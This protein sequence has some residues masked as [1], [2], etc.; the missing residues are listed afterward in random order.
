MLHHP[1][2][3]A[4]VANVGGRRWCGC[5]NGGRQQPWVADGGAVGQEHMEYLDFK[6]NAPVI[7]PP[8]FAHDQ[9]I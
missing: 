5:V 7:R 9:M 4:A 6:V 8:G 3:T 2:A 1:E